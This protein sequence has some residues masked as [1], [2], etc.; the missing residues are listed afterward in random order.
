V[1][2]LTGEEEALHSLEPLKKQVLSLVRTLGGMHASL[3]ILAGT[4]VTAGSPV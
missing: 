3:S 4:A 1:L 2:R